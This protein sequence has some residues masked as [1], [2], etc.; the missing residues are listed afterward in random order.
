MELADAIRGRRSVRKY[1]DKGVPTETILKAIELACWAPNGG[2]F[3]PWRFFVVKSRRIIDRMADAVQAKVDLMAGWPEAAEFGQ[4]FERY[5][6]TASFFRHAPAVIAI[7]MGG[8]QSSA[9]KVLQKR[10]ETDPEARDMI[11]NRA[12]INSRIQTIAGAT[13]YLLLALHEQGLSSCWMAG[14]MLARREIERMLE[15]P[16]GV[17]LFALVPV[18]YAAGTP[19]P[20]PRKPLEDVVRVLE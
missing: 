6:A 16:E 1:Q 18:G 9:D 10:S 19:A 13:G 17:E 8:Y 7:G 2:N 5:R 3:Q 4:T 11:R 14:P 12:E 15:I 20:G